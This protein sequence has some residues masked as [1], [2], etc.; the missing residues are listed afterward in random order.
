MGY[1]KE[2]H[3]GW[4]ELFYDLVFA[5]AIAQLGQNLSHDVSVFGFIKYVTLFVLVCWA[6]TGSTFYASRF[7]VD[8]LVH[9][10][11]ILLQMGGAVA[12]AVNIHD[13]FDKT[14]IGFALSY[15]TIRIFLIIEYL[16]TGHKF[17]KTRP[18][19]SKYV[20]GFSFTSI[21]WL[22]SIFVPSPFRYVIWILAM[23][24]DIIITVIVTRTHTDLLPNT[25]HLSE[26]FGLFVI[27]VLGETIFGLVMGLA[28]KEWSTMTVLDMGT[29]ITIA[30]G[31][32]WIYFD[33]IDGSAIRALK[34]Q[35]RIRIYLTWLYLHFPLLIGI[36][37]FGD[38]ISHLIK[39]EQNLPITYSDMWL[40]C[41]SV[42]LCL[43]CIGFLQLVIFEA[44]SL[45]RTG[46]KWFFHRF[47]SAF[48]V[49]GIAIVNIKIAP[50]TLLFALSLICIIQVVIDLRYHPHHRIFKL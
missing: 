38:G 10:V 15:I 18:L 41:M 26:R 24:V 49:V 43:F 7:N 11:L 12:L 23:L 29:G 30:F 34:E 22:L 50:I 39:S 17:V 4:L 27:I 14:S 1:E 35:R 31:L 33:T 13:A 42:A 8:D 2:R 46:L 28:A 48:A 37:A 3:T 5:A 36:A 9:R 45:R 32:W 6:W 44:N 40:M 21:L 25:F 19:T 47:I 16:R 20:M